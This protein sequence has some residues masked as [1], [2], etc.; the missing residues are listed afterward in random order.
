MLLDFLVKNYDV[1]LT[2]DETLFFVIFL[3]IDCIK[4]ILVAFRI[5]DKM[6]TY[7]L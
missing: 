3:F 4:N 1:S 6:G 5:L 7:L 2:V